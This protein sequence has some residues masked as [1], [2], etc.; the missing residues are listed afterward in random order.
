MSAP[1]YLETINQ[2]YQNSG[3]ALPTGIADQ[4]ANN[5]INTDWQD[6][7]FRTGQVHDYNVGISQGSK[8]ATFSYRLDTTRTKVFLIANDF[9]RASLRVNSETKKGRFSF[10][11]NIMLSNSRGQLSWRWYQCIL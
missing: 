5:T 3:V 10:G 11:E 1:Q 4:V 2:Q 6:E 7:V 9:E 8:T